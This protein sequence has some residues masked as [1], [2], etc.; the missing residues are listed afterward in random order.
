MSFRWICV[1]FGGRAVRPYE[2]AHH[3][4]TILWGRLLG[5]AWIF[6]ENGHPFVCFAD[7]SPARGITRPY[8]WCVAVGF[9]QN[10]NVPGAPTPTGCISP[11]DWEKSNA[12]AGDS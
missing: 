4:E 8:G 1:D 9:G 2:V 3:F 12:V 6:S 10:P 5:R 11:L 7:I